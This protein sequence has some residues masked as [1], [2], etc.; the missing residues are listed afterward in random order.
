[1]FNVLVWLEVSKVE[2]RAQKDHYEKPG[3]HTYDLN[4]L[5]K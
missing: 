5:N 1:M 2:N 3:V 4:C